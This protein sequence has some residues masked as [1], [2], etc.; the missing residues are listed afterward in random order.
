MPET[1]HNI[2][3]TLKCDSEEEWEKHKDF[4]PYKGEPIVVFDQ[5]G[6]ARLKI[7]DGVRSYGELKFIDGIERT[8]ILSEKENVPVDNVDDDEYIR[9][10]LGG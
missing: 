9:V 3:F 10:A 1:R 4:I 7:G 8:P 2:R 6:D 5:F